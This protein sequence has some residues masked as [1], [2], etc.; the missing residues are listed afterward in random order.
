M[1]ESLIREIYFGTYDP[2][3]SRYAY[4][5]AGSEAFDEILAAYEELMKEAPDAFKERLR[6]FG[7]MCLSLLSERSE[8]DF[9]EG[10]RLGVRLMLEALMGDE[11]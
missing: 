2:K 1:K 6:R 3:R 5:D 7:D 11:D 9:M 10:Y 4:A 8:L